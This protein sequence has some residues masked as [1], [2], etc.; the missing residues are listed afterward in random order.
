M[1]VTRRGVIDVA[2]REFS[3]IRQDYLILSMTFYGWFEAKF[4]SLALQWQRVYHG[5]SLSSSK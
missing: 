3:L 4:L 5:I 1:A 2:H